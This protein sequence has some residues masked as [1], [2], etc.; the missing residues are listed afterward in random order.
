KIGRMLAAEI[1]AGSHVYLDAGST[2][3]EVG[4]SLL[5]RGDCPL[6]TNS[7]PL[8]YSAGD[9]PQKITGVGGTLRNLTGAL[10]GAPALA[11]IRQLQFDV[12]VLGAS[13]L[14]PDRGA[15]TTELSEAA[16]KQAAAASG[17]RIL[18]AAVAEKIHSSAPVCFIPWE[19][20]DLWFTDSAEGLELSPELRGKVR[21]CEKTEKESV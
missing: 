4:M 14:S 18:L 6:Y 11:L 3:L 10:V 16:V 20:V 12:V 7:V 9:Y 19:K 21:S 5:A 17:K 1:P 13:G 15:F 8:L 2:C